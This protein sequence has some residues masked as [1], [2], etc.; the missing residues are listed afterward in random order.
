MLDSNVEA[1]FSVLYTKRGKMAFVETRFAVYDSKVL[2]IDA[3]EQHKRPSL[4]CCW[5]VPHSYSLLFMT[6]A[7]SH[8]VYCLQRIGACFQQH[9][10]NV[11]KASA[12]A[13]V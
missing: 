10:C 5:H 4:R 11:E 8:L 12:A 3:F 13:E 2:Q 9:G 6:Q 1:G 7:G